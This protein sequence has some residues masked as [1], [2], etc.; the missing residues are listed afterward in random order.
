MR[1][2]ALD[3]RVRELAR[4]TRRRG[5]RL[6][7]RL[8]G[9]RPVPLRRALTPVSRCYGF[10]RGTP[11]DRHYIDDFMARHGR[12][13]GYGGGDLRGRV[14][15]V[16]G[17]EYATRCGGDIRRLDVLHVSDDNPR[18]TLVG[19]LVSGAG[20]A[21]EAHDCVICTQTLH[22]IY[23]VRAAVATLHRILD[24]GGVALVTVPGIAAA[25]RPDR[26]LWGDYWRFTGLSVRRLFEE[27]FA[28]ADVKVEAY[29]NVVAAA[30][31]LY[32]MAAEEL[33]PDQLDARDPDY[34][35]LLGVRARKAS[36]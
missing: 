19:D 8:T 22:V 11:I 31:F 27:R 9:R 20:L 24:A 15:E 25:S 34:E 7:A 10:D 14:L 4:A 35:V 26:D 21:S 36:P 16:G 6:Q 23:D 2:S 18:A 29:G 32:G 3:P 30:A 28:P 1:R 12:A 33:R 5:L 13:E 17:D